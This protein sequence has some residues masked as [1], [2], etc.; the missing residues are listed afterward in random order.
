M[1]LLLDTQALLWWRAGS[2][3]LGRRARQ[4]I[5]GDAVTVSVSAASVWEIA[6]KSSLG[7]LRLRDPLETWVPDALEQHGFAMLSVTVAHAAAVGGLPHHHGDPFDRLLIAQ[8]RLD[9]L[10]I[11]TS[12]T[13]FDDYDV[14]VLD[15]RV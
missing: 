14:D 3:R 8:A 2:R 10:T 4:A 12:D 5:E 1:N 6:I 9:R 7:R 15:A 11:V 13:V